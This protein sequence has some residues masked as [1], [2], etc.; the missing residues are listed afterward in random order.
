MVNFD[1]R[2]QSSQVD[3]DPRKI[4]LMNAGACGAFVHGLE[5]EFMGKVQS[6][7]NYVC[8]C[9]ND[10]INTFLNV[11]PHSYLPPPPPHTQR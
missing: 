4:S 1:T 9:N 10:T 2:T 3:I 11:N 5:D 8:T 7:L 6:A